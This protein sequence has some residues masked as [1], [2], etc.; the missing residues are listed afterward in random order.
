MDNPRQQP[1]AELAY[2]TLQQLEPDSQ[3][4][5]LFQAT[6]EEYFRNP[7]RALDGMRVKD[8]PIGS[9]LG[10][11]ELILTPVL[12]WL[13]G[14]LLDLAWDLVKKP[15]EEELSDPVSRFIRQLLQRF[16]LVKPDQPDHFPALTPAQKEQLQRLTLA[17]GEF[18][19]LAKQHA[20]APDLTTQLVTVMVNQIPTTAEDR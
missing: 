7:Q 15:I 17:D 10:I 5:A 14:K 16:G 2:E 11:G 13:G 1:V 20:L 18:Q 4:L 6:Q 8:R 19:K 3:E 9:G 12:L